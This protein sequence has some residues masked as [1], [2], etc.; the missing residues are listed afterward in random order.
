MTEDA[1]TLD[2]HHKL[3]RA[4]AS[5]LLR[6]GM[7]ASSRSGR[8]LGKSQRH[9]SVDREAHDS[10]HPAARAQLTIATATDRCYGSAGADERSAT[11]AIARAAGRMNQ[12][13][14]RRLQ[15]PAA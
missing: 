5:F 6:H 9:A 13:Q 8:T 3:V 11:N 10:F 1:D 12:H 2:E 15:S 4:C 7:G 14:C